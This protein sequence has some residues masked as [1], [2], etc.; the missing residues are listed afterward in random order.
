[1]CCAVPGSAAD[2]VYLGASSAQVPIPDSIP[3][4]PSSDPAALAGALGT[5][6]QACE[7]VLW[8]SR[9]LPSPAAP[10]GAGVP[11]SPGAPAA[12]PLRDPRC[13]K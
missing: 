1:M 12:S 7:F 13:W 4:G 8:R 6:L 9:A 3:V 5:V 11:G 2:R 10:L